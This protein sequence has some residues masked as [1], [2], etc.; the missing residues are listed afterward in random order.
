MG[1]CEFMGDVL[2]HRTAA[3][4]VWVE[5]GTTVQWPGWGMTVVAIDG[6]IAALA[7]SGQRTKVR[8]RLRSLYQVLCEHAQRVCLYRFQTIQSAVLAL[9]RSTAYVIL[10]ASPL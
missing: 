4:A 6:R 7:D 10:C 5:R 1:K 3:P 2:W 8:V 9:M